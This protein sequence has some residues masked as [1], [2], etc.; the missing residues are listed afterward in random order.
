MQVV[1]EDEHHL[2]AQPLGFVRELVPYTAKGPLM[3]TL[4]IGGAGII[5]LPNSA[6]IANNYRLYSLCMQSRNQSGRLLMLDIL[7]LVLQFLE[8]FLFGTNKLL[9]AA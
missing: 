2:H 9:T 7:D 6:H 8:L 3:D 5:V 4:V 1:L